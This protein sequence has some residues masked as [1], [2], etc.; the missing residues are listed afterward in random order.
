MAGIVLKNIDLTGITLDE[1]IEKLDEEIM[2]LTYELVNGN[3]ETITEE[4]WDVVQAVMGLIQLNNGI[5]A[6]QLMAEYYKHEE[7]LKSRPRD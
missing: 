5:T 1:E 4:F 2:E 7:K 6:E 3:R